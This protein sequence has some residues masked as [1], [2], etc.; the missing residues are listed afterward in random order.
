MASRNITVTF[1]LL[2]IPAKLEKATEAKVSNTNMCVG[3][4]GHASHE[5]MPVRM[6]KSC[7]L[8]GTITDHHAL[9]KGI[10]EG[11]TY[12]IVTQEE[13]A[14]KKAEFA[15]AYKGAVNLVPH[16]AEEFFGAT[17]QGASISYV[18]PA[19][20]AA[21]QHYMLLV[22]L[23]EAHPELAFASLYTPVSATGLYVVRAHDGVLVLEERT[24]TQELKAAP[25]VTGDVNDALYTM[26]EA[27]LDGFI[28][29]YDP[30]AYEDKYATALRKLAE[31][32]DVAVSLRSGEEPAATGVHADDDLMEKLRQLKEAS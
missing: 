27:V 3:Q 16:P 2:S 28:T 8:C 21:A 5:A 30:E 17:G 32:S 26:L 14:E 9:V 24:R 22:K 12:K 19:T 29:P 7:E 15:G 4:P 31:E 11:S 10:K 23:V 6:P 13:V 25:V 18:T 20:D 1:G